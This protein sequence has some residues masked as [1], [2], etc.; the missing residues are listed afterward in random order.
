MN[1]ESILRRSSL[2]IW[3]DPGACR[4]C[5]DCELACSYHMSDHKFFSPNLSSTKVLRDNDDGT[6][7]MTIYDTCDLCANE[8]V[9]QCVKYC[10]FGARGVKR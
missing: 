10:A 5:L 9:P 2:R 4:G 1:H 7:S 6:V 3:M 8:D